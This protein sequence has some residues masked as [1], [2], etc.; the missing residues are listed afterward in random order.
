MKPSTMGKAPEPPVEKQRKRLKARKRKGNIPSLIV[1]QLMRLFKFR[2]GPV[3]PDDDA[4]R[5]DALLLL[6]FIAVSAGADAERRMDNFL[7]VSCPWMTSVEAA[8]LKQAACSARTRYKADELGRIVNLTMEDRMRLK[9]TSIG[10]V[11]CDA[12]QRIVAAR[13]RKAQKERLRR[14]LK[15]ENSKPSDI[16]ADRVRLVTEAAPFET[17]RAMKNVIEDVARH[18]AFDLKSPKQAVHEAVREAERRGL[19]RT[20]IK[21]GPRKL[22]TLLIRRTWP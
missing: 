4:G 3:L 18:K 15:G 10:A 13:E 20:E 17:S 21:I 7:E 1:M 19:L 16:W 6:A 22:P 2:Y 14:K 8:K 12:D 9:I 5:E 11:D